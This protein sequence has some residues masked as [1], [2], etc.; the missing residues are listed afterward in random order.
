LRHY[1]AI[2]I[3]LVLGL[4][5]YMIYNGKEEEDV[6]QLTFETEIKGG[7]IKDVVDEETAR[8]DLYR[9]FDE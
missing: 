1:L 4:V 9:R 3:A 7:K 2:G 5:A 8:E 6:E